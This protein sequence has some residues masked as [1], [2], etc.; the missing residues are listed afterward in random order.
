L[1]AKVVPPTVG[2]SDGQL[3]MILIARR[4]LHAN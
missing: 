4:A 3:E 1:P 2:V